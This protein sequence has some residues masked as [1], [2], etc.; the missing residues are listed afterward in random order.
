MG[1]RRRVQQQVEEE[2]EVARGVGDG[3]GI[4]SVVRSGHI[5]NPVTGRLIKIGGDVYNRLVLEEGYTPDVAQGVLVQ[6]RAA[7]GGAGP[8]RSSGRR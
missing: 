4:S 7:N 2:P 6:L 5:L 1:A 8:S 3:A